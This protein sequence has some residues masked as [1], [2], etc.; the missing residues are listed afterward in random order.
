M[1][2]QGEVR[3]AS[4][5]LDAV[6]APPENVLFSGLAPTLAGVNLVVVEVPPGVDPSSEAEVVIAIGGRASQPGVTIAV[7]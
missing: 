1:W 4:D 5:T 3:P 7:E 2:S 6:Q